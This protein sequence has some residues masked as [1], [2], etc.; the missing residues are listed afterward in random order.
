MKIKLN[1]SLKTT[2][3]KFPDYDVKGDVELP[4]EEILNILGFA[5]GM[6]D[7]AVL[8]AYGSRKDQSQNWNDWFAD[9]VSK[10][11]QRMM[12]ETDGTKSLLMDAAL[13]GEKK[14]TEVGKQKAAE[15]LGARIKDLERGLEEKEAEHKKKVEEMT[16]SHSKALHMSRQ[17]AYG[18]CLEAVQRA[19]ANKFANKSQKKLRDEAC[20]AVQALYNGV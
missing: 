11:T 4:Y 19:T 5:G 3:P 12:M 7:T 14:G 20:D 10:Q 16:E 17:M 2:S 18:K 8:E 15:A 6:N 9:F 13:T 1:L